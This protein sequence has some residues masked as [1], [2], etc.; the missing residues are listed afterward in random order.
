MARLGRRPLADPGTCATHGPA[1]MWASF[2]AYSGCPQ[3]YDLSV[4]CGARPWVKRFKEWGRDHPGHRPRRPAGPD[5]PG[6]QPWLDLA[7][8]GRAAW[9]E[10]QEVRRNAATPPRGNAAPAAPRARLH[11]G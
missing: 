3:H 4:G 5:A 9:R 6:W 7:G 10:D 8:C 2:L 11:S 1:A